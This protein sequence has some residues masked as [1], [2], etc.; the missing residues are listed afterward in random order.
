GEVGFDYVYSGFNVALTGYWNDLRNAISNFTTKNNPV[1][2]ED[3]ERGRANF[4]LVRIRGVEFEGT[5]QVSRPFQLYARYI[6]SDAP[7]LDAPDPALD[8]RFVTQVP[9]NAGMAGLRYDDQRLCTFSIQTR[10]ESLKYED[11]DN[12]DSLAGYFTIDASLWRA[13][14]PIGP[15]T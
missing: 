7:T 1:T 5:Y 13:L 14:P 6:Y 15:L 12:H 11:S 10:A 8:G 3:L 9:R 2:G 4:R